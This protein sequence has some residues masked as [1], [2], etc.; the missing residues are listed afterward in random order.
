MLIPPSQTDSLSLCAIAKLTRVIL[1]SKY[2]E[3]ISSCL[4]TSR[5]PPRTA[6]TVPELFAIGEAIPR[7]RSVWT[8]G[9][10][11]SQRTIFSWQV[12]IFLCCSLTFL[13]FI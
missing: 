2:L 13:N 9:G 3:N 12:R 11:H 5:T 6:G 4:P 1:K 8:F 10:Q 7:A